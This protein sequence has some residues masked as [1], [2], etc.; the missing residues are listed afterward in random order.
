MRIPEILALGPPEQ[1]PAAV[2]EAPV[3]ELPPEPAIEIVAEPAAAP[4]P[5]VE[6]PDP[7]QLGLF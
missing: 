4:Q 6:P 3:E 7:E 1:P 2:T 5:L